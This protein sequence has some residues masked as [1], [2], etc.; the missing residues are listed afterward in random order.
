MDR[1]DLEKD[2]ILTSPATQELIDEVQKKISLILPRDY[3]DLLLI[4]NGIYTSGCLGIHP[5][6]DMPERNIDYQVDKYMPGFFM[7]GD[8]GGGQAI[9]IN[10]I[11]EVFEV[12]MGVMD[13]ED[14]EI[15]ADSLE[16]LLIKYKG[17]T[18]SERRDR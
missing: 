2:F 11:G 9:I 13:L 14:T 16:E 12:G 1:R 8:D 18:L 7:I 5:I 3:K 4:S 10:E 6:E 15:S 17:K